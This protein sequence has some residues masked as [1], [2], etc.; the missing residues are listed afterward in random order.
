MAIIHRYTSS[1]FIQEIEQI[2]P[3]YLPELFQIVHI[4][5]ESITKK[6]TLD[7]FEASWQQAVNGETYPIEDLWEGIDAE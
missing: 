3:Q 6:T 1:E 5:R 7:S 4:F 2:P